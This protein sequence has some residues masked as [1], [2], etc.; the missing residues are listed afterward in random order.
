MPASAAGDRRQCGTFHL[1]PD[2]FSRLGQPCHPWRRSAG[3]A[4]VKQ[5]PLP[6]AAQFRCPVSMVCAGKDEGSA[7]RHDWLR[8]RTYPSDWL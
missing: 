4:R 2:S 1:L 5:I 6:Q 8:R 7:D 3:R